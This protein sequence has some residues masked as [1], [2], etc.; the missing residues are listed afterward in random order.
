MFGCT[1]MRSDNTK[2][3][4]ILGVSKSASQEELRKAYHNDARKKHPDK[5]G[6]PEKVN[7]SIHVLLQLVHG[8]FGY[9]K[10]YYTCRNCYVCICVFVL[11]C[12]KPFVCYSKSVQRA[13]SS[14]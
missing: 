4:E 2:Y 14:L 12:L 7:F 1:Q 3:Y 10:I 11:R 8:F 13:V 6:D 5:G 9:W